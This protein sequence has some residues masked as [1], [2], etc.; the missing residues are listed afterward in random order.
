MKV[1]KNKCIG[2]RQCFVYCPVR[3]IHM[4]DRKADIDE[5]ACLECHICY[6]S[7]ICP[8]DALYIDALSY[9]RSLR[10][11]FSDVK[12]PHKNTGVLGRGTE[13]MKTNDVTGRM[14]L[15]HI[16][17]SVELGR[18]GI[19]ASFKDVE[20]IS[21]ALAPLGVHFEEENPVTS[22]MTDKTT[23]AL[24]PEILN[25]R[26]LSALVEIEIS[27][28]QLMDVIQALKKVESKVNTV[29]SLSAYS[30]VDPRTGR[31]PTEDILR[32]HHIFYRPNG[33]TNVGL[34]R[35]FKEVERI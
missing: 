19:S 14:R 21:M 25:E 11:A 24:R 31:A 33:K 3:A 29:F 17:V 16:G 1:D 34:G 22:L 4:K 9:P 15:G 10:S 8:K 26:V 12:C 5:S 7:G 2:C 20:I 13:E 18:P 6:Y 23:G 27:V 30:P 35:P 28:D 32:S